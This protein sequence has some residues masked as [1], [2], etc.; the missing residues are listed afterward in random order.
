MA[1]PRSP[2]E[3]YLLKVSLPKSILQVMDLHL[4]DPMT[5]KVKYG[6]RSRLMTELISNWLATK[7]RPEDHQRL[8]EEAEKILNANINPNDDYDGE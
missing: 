2:Q 1:R 8:I 7:I 3:M 5:G 4:I 6:A